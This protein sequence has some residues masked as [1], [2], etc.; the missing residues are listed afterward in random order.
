M[1]TP[2]SSLQTE[3]LS[4]AQLRAAR[5]LLNLSVAELAEQTGLAINTIRRAER[6]NGPVPISVANANLLLATLQEGGVVFLD[7]D[8][9]GPGVRLRKSEA[10]PDRP[11]RRA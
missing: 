11:R 2:D 6:S 5:G 9:M 7:A 8:D 4:G 1:S 3:V 10:L